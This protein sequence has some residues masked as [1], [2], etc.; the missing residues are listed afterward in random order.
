[1]VTQFKPIIVNN[2]K[3]VSKEVNGGRS[4]IKKAINSKIMAT[5]KATII[6]M[7]YISIR[8]P[9]PLLFILLASTFPLS[10][11][12]LSLSL[13]GLTHITYELLYI[14]KNI[15]DKIPKQLVI[16]MLFLL[17]ALV[18]LKIINF[19]K[20][21][22]YLLIIEFAVIFCLL[23]I[24]LYFK[25]K[26]SS[27]LIILAFAI[28]FIINPVLLFLALAFFHNLTPWGFLAVSQAKHKAWIVFI[29]NPI[30]VFILSLFLSLD[31]SYFA[32]EDKLAY[33]MH[34]LRPSDISPYT[35]AFFASAVYLQL[36]HYY[37]V[38]LILPKLGPE[39][40]TIN[41]FVLVFFILFGMGFFYNF[42]LWKQVYGI[43]SMFHSYLEIPLLFYLLPITTK[44]IT[45]NL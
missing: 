25:V 26:I 13:F 44:R 9:F 12:F 45:N 3:N 40:L 17:T 22:D 18:F 42:Y 19:I 27:G 7:K 14:R 1:M 31:W 35:V 6:L 10:S 30:L 41:K 16:S 23:L 34:Y 11:Y 33:I 39:K 32:S 36:I 21:I 29:L 37:Y 38:I 4:I 20:P 5:S 15:V 2:H 24:T 28:A 43:A 8:F